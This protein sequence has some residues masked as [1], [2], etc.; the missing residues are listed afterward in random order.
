[1]QP[2]FPF[3]FL[4]NEEIAQ[5]S[6]EDR[7]AYLTRAAEELRRVSKENRLMADRLLGKPRNLRNPK[8]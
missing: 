3:R 6:L 2:G 4:S 5:L 8:T 7:A 1:M